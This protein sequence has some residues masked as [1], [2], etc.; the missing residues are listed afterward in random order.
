MN[1]KVI[2]IGREF[3]SGGRE[4]GIRLAEELQI[5][6]Y[7]KE[8][9]TLAAEAGGIDPNLV[10]ENEEKRGKGTLG[11]MSF[12]SFSYN[13][14]L[15]DGI[16]L[17]QCSVIRSLAEQGPCVIVGRCADFV[18]KEKGAVNVFL[19]AS[20][21]YKIQRK[22]AMAAEKADYTDGQMAKYIAAVDNQRR[23]YYEHYTGQ[24]WGHIENYHLCIHSD[25]VGVDG[26]VRTILTYLEEAAKIRSNDAK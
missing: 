14:T 16:F 4:V 13:P 15:S 5:P 3:G 10:A 6:F 21:P 22:R 12:A 17:H 25:L 26:A 20:I 1:S 18:L 19:A 24:K 8:I 11:R 2:T 23:N 7:D 9:I